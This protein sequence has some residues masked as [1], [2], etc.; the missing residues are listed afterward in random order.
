MHRRVARAHTVRDRSELQ[1]RLEVRRQAGGL[2]GG[3][4]YPVVE[5]GADAAALGLVFDDD[6]AEEAAAGCEASAHGVDTGEHAVQSEGHVV[7]FGEL[8]DG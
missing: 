6:E 7:V 8:E 3:I 1:R 2:F 4:E 5:G